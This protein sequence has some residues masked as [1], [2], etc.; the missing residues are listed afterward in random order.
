LN[1]APR[2]KDGKE[3]IEARLD[4]CVLLGVL[5]AN[6]IYRPALT[7]L[8]LQMKRELATALPAFRDKLI[9]AADHFPWG[10]ESMQTSSVLPSRWTEVLNRMQEAVVKCLAIE[11]PAH[12]A[13]LPPPTILPIVL[14]KVGRLDAVAKQAAQNAAEADAVLQDNAD[15][16]YRWQVACQ[17]TAQ[18][19]AD[20]LC[21]KVE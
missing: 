2:R 9:D 21:D 11:V 1:C 5:R 12:R 6:G 18:K 17:E 4:L 16:L 13:E 3:E 7:N 19:L 8:A 20:H 15:E 10:E 14:P